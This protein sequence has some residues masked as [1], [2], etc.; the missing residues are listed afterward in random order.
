MRFTGAKMLRSEGKAKHADLIGLEK[1]LSN[2]C[3]IITYGGGMACQLSAAENR[4]C[5]FR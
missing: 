1:S 3:Y 5:G 2:M 4:S